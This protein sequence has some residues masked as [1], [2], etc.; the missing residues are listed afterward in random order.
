MLLL[1][2]PNIFLQRTSSLL[3]PLVRHCIGVFRQISEVFQPRTDE[4]DGP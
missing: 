1:C 4:V 2:L 3:A